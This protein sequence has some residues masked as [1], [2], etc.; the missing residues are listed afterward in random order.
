MPAD[1]AL[2]VLALG[3]ASLCYVAFY[4][5]VGLL[6]I[7]LVRRWVRIDVLGAALLQVVLVLMGCGLPPV[8][9]ALSLQWRSHGWTFLQVTNFFWTLMDLADRQRLA[10]FTG[11]IVVVLPA[12]ALAVFVLNLRAVLREVAY[13]RVAKPARVAEEDAA[14]APPPPPPPRASPWD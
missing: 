10:P 7:R 2:W 1:R 5:G 14:L 8:L 9:Q 11:E 3:V 12:M 13:V 4:L 6:L